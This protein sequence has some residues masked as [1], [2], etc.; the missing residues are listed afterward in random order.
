MVLSP[1]GY[2]VQVF[3][4]EEELA[5]SAYF[6]EQGFVVVANV[7]SAPQALDTGLFGAVL[8][9]GGEFGGA[10]EQRKPAERP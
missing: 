9:G 3:E 6:R 1:R 8:V 7:L 10:V 5:Y 2:E 4:P